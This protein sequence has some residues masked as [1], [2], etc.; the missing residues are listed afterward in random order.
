MDK[1][2]QPPNTAIWQQRLSHF[3]DALAHNPMPGCGAAATVVASLG[4][5]LILKGLHISQ[6]HQTS[7]AR[8]VLIEQGEGRGL[9]ARALLVKEY[10]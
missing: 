5:A 2:S 6:Q 10:A 8:A 7:E 3:R 1:D 9:N 4:L